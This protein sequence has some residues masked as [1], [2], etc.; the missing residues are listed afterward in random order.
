MKLDGDNHLRARLGI[1]AGRIPLPARLRYCPKC[2]I[3]DREKYKHAYW[4]RNHQITGVEVCHTHAAFLESSLI[5]WQGRGHSSSKFHSAEQAVSVISPRPLDPSN[6]GHSIYLSI[7]LNA[8]WLLSQR[9]LLLDSGVLRHRYYNLL[10]KRGYAYYNGRIRTTQLLNA[11]TQFYPSKFLNAIHCPINSQSYSWLIRLLSTD[12]VDIVH[13]S[14]R[15]LLLIIFLECTAEQVF[16]SF[17]EYKPFSDGPWP[18]LNHAASHYKQLTIAQCRITDCM[19]KK[20]RGRPMGTFSCKC[21]FAYNRIGPDNSTEDRFR[22]GSIQCYGPTW[23]RALRK[24]WANVSIPI[25]E[26]SRRLGV[27]DLTVVRHAI[28]LC[29]PMNTQGTRRVN[30]YE[31][32]SSYRQTIHDARHQYRTEWLAVRRANPKASRKQLIVIASFL[33]QWLRKNDS[34]W[35]EKHLPS[36]R[37]INRKV[38][39]KDWKHEDRRLAAAFKASA[40]GIK[41]LPGRPVRASIAAITR[42]I[43]HRAW[44]ERRLADLPLTAKAI[45][46]HAESLEAYSIRKVKWA[47]AEFRQHG[48]CPTRLQLMARA[49]IRNK[50]GKTPAVQRAIDAAIARLQ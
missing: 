15:H 41:Y 13:H 4:H 44:I 34:E 19:I 12:K 43:S 45:R 32:Y 7:A 39:R 3:D 6:R 16:T 22:A 48:I 8:A 47:E 14:L 35:I 26:M 1:T 21:G 18:C 31:R 24:L 50:T 36:V 30:G 38:K 46:T 49:T 23:E 11:F 2:V 37:K 10:L 20:K 17:R 5:P 29:L 9:G 25:K 40:K 42:E 28:R 27:S 33:Y